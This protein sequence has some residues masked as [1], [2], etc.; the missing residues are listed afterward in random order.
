MSKLDH[1]FGDDGEFWMKYED[2]LRYSD[3]IERTRLYDETWSIAQKWTSVK[4]PWLPQYLPTKFVVEF[5]EAG[6]VVFL[7]TQL[8][9]RCFKGLQ[10]R[11][12][13][14][15]SYVVRKEGAELDD[16]ILSVPMNTLNNRAKSSG[17]VDIE[18]GRYEVLIKI[19]AYENDNPEP[20]SL[21]RS[22]IKNAPTKLKQIAANYDYAHS[23]LGDEKIEEDG[24]K[25]VEDG[26]KEDKDGK[27]ED[28]DGEKEDEGEGEE[29]IKEK[30]WDPV[31]VI[32]LRVF[33]Q[34]SA[35]NVTVVK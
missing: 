18:P 9:E 15:T 10:G 29:E 4:V 26:K 8:D 34:D 28:E 13:F 11:Y 20:L 3:D 1:C 27:K 7:L 30:C 19:E 35:I 12:S 5:S 21:V 14:Q 17:E 32:G 31:A 2:F 6:T 16:Y 23:I 33:A 25:E 24:K 22:A